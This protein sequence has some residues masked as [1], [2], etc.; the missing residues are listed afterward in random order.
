MLD[1]IWDCL[2]PGINHPGTMLDDD[3]LAHRLRSLSIPLAPRSAGPQGTVTTTL[4]ASAEDSALPDRMPVTV[5]PA[6]RGW[7]IRFGSL[8][9]VDVGHTRWQESVALVRPVR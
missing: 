9:E 7:V 3:A 2:L 8:F 1:A 6:D 5:E 4:D